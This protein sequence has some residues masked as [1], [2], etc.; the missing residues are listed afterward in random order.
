LDGRVGVLQLITSQDYCLHSQ[1]KMQS[2]Y[3]VPKILV[4]FVLHIKSSPTPMV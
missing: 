4:Q 3:Y 2:A 1:F